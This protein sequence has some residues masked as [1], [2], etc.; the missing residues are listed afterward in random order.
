MLQEEVIFKL[1]L[2]E[3]ASL[4]QKK[5]KVYEML[6]TEREYGCSW[7]KVPRKIGDGLVRMKGQTV[8]L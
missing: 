6:G 8:R 3:P 7:S 4:S 5:G 2:G 1:E